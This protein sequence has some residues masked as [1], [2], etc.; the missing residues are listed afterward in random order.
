MESLAYLVMGILAAQILLGALPLTF[1]ILYRVKG[2]FAVTSQV[3]IALLVLQMAWGFSVAPAFGYL[4]L[5][6]LVSS[7]IVRWVKFK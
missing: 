3:L 7:A 5:T 6:F 4:S 1:S 2:K